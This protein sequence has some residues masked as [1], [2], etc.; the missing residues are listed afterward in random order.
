MLLN[1]PDFQD[2]LEVLR[3]NPLPM[4]ILV[5]FA[6]MLVMVM[7]MEM[8]IVMVVKAVFIIPLATEIL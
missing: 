7:V 4:C 3:I 1:F 6:A 5:R 8:V 2:L